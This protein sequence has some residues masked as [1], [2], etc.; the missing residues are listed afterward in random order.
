MTVNGQLGTGDW[1]ES[2]GLVPHLF[3]QEVIPV[4]ERCS[5]PLDLCEKWGFLAA[6]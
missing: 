3:E 6:T 1:D 5:S 2:K 4:P